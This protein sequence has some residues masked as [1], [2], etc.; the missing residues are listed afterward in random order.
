MADC[1]ASL[2]PI[3]NR[4]I[5]SGSF[6]NRASSNSCRAFSLRTSRHRTPRESV[7]M[8]NRVARRISRYKLS[9]SRRVLVSRR[10][11]KISSSSSSQLFSFFTMCRS[12]S[13]STVSGPSC[14]KRPLRKMQFPIFWLK[15]IARFLHFPTF[16]A[17]VQSAPISQHLLF[18]AT[19]AFFHLGSNRA[20]LL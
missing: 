9:A 15:K 3:S 16:I 11:L 18:I 12:N 4:V 10:R 8:K 19:T 5:T 6:S 13:S 17:S 20:H 7:H 1:T 14:R 2:P